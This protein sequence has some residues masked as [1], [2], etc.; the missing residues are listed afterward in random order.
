MSLSL[1]P[2]FNH[3]ISKDIY[4]LYQWARHWKREDARSCPFLSDPMITLIP[5]VKLNRNR[6]NGDVAAKKSASAKI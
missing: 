6:K 4:K 2:Y 1:F 5:G 3:L